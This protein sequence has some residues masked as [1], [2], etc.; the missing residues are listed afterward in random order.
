ME[1]FHFLA[2][3]GAVAAAKSDF[4]A[5]ADGAAVNAANGNAAYV[6]AEIQRGYQHLRGSGILG[7]PGNGVDYGVE[8]RQDIVGGVPEVGA[9]PS[10]LGRAVQSG[11]V[12]LFFGCVEIEHEVEHHLLHFLGA[13][14]GFVHLIYNNHRL[15]ADLYGFLEHETCLRHRTLESV[16]QQQAAVGHVEH[17]FHLAAEIGV[18]GGVYDIY[19]VAFIVD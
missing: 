13:A 6:F 17:P 5:F 14:V 16:D 3:H 4:L 18:A 9:H 10:L 19:L 7:G 1:L 8:Q 15:E 11:E 12:Q 2:A